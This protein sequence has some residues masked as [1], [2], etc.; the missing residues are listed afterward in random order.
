MTGSPV[1]GRTED[2]VTPAAVNGRPLTVAEAA[3]ALRVSLGTIYAAIRRGELVAYAF[4]SGRGTYRIERGDLAEYKKQ[5]ATTRRPVLPMRGRAA[6][7]F[8]HLDATRLA[9]RWKDANA[10]AAGHSPTGSADQ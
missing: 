8:R 9:S 10:I 7:A 1:T 5:H 2:D 6:G 4:G 3:A